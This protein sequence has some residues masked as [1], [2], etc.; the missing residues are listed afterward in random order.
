MKRDANEAEIIQALRSVGANVVQM[1]YPV[2]LLVTFRGN[3]YAIEVKTAKGK[4]TESQ[5]QFFEAFGTDNAGV[6][7]NVD[8]ALRIIGAIE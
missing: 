1:D 8:D 3:I 4:L 6:A 7:R 2:D 5:V